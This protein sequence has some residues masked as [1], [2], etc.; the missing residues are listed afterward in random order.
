MRECEAAGDAADDTLA[1][2]L[3]NDVIINDNDNDSDNNNNNEVRNSNN[4]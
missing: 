4:D 2:D 3:F 1:L